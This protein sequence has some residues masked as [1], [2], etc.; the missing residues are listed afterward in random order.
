MCLLKIRFW[1][2]VALSSVAVF[3]CSKQPDTVMLLNIDSLLDEQV[4]RLAEAR[5]RLEKHATFGSVTDDSTYT[6]PDATAWDSE[7][8]VFRQLHVINKPINRKNYLVDDGLFDVHS[9][10]TVKALSAL[11]NLPVRYIRIF[12]HDSIKK[13]RKIEALY[14]D[15]NQLSKSG[16]LI[17]LEF[18]QI[19]NHTLL[20]A[21]SISGGQK[22]IFGDTVVFDVKAKIVLD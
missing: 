12:Y 3:S 16:R 9:N 19:N 6:P 2:V 13:P 11:E 10:L 22:I 5:A 8:A 1:I 18:Q 17:T 21:Y 14:R 7:L 15:E 20:T 4:S